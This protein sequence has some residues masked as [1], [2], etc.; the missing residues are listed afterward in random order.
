MKYR[1]LRLLR[2]TSVTDVRVRIFLIDRLLQH[3]ELNQTSIASKFAVIGWVK[4][5]QVLDQ[6]VAQP[7]NGLQHD[8]ARVMVQSGS[9]AHHVAR[10]GTMRPRLVDESILDSLKFNVAN[11]FIVSS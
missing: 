5:G 8:A 10:L 11:G 7:G 9:L 1:Q 3:K 4:R 6:G 2:Q